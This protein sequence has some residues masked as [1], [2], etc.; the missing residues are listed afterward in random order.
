PQAYGNHERK[1]HGD[2]S[3]HRQN[4]LPGE[5]TGWSR[6]PYRN[7]FQ[8]HRRANQVRRVTGLAMGR[9]VCHVLEE[10]TVKSHSLAHLLAFTET[11]RHVDENDPERI[12]LSSRSINPT[13]VDKRDSLASC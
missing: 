10:I 7:S 5:R 4:G 13:L 2:D 6:R 8:K 1:D 12:G 3:H 11:F 9:L